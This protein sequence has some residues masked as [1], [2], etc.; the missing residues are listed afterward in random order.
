MLTE[1]VLQFIPW[2]HDARTL[3]KTA[4]FFFSFICTELPSAQVHAAPYP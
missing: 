2:W 4:N 1:N 3:A